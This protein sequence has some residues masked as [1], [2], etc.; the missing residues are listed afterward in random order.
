MS[1]TNGY[2]PFKTADE[3]ADKDYHIHSVTGDEYIFN[4]EKE[5]WRVMS[6]VKNRVFHS[7]TPPDRPTNAQGLDGYLPRQGDM[8]WDTNLMELRVWHEPVPEDPL[9][10]TPPGRWISSTNPHMSPLSPVKNRV[11]GKLALLDENDNTFRYTQ[12]Y[13]DTLYRIRCERTDST[14]EESLIGYSWTATPPSIDGVPVKFS[15]PSAAETSVEIPPLRRDSDGNVLQQQVSITC[16]VSAID[17]VETFIEPTK[18]INTGAMPIRDVPPGGQVQTGNVNVK[19][20]S[21]SDLGQPS[22]DSQPKYVVYTI[23]NDSFAFSGNYN[24]I[25]GWPPGRETYQI[26][27]ANISLTNETVLVDFVYETDS[28]MENYYLAFY[29]DPA[30][31]VP[32]GSTEVGADLGVIDPTLRNHRLIVDKEFFGNIYFTKFPAG[33]ENTMAGHIEWGQLPDP[34]GDIG[35]VTITGSGYPKKNVEETYSI[36]YAGSVPENRVTKTLTTDDPLAVVNGNK[37]TFGTTGYHQV[38]AVVKSIYASDSPQT[39]TIGVDV[40]PG[41]NKIGEFKISGDDRAVVG[42]PN[43]YT[44]SYDGDIV[45]HSVEFTTNDSGA[46]I[47]GGSIVFSQPGD[48]IVNGRITAT[49]S[50]EGYV[51]DFINVNVLT[52]IPSH[53]EMSKDEVHT[54]KP[55]TYLMVIDAVLNNKTHTWSTTRSSGGTGIRSYPEGVITHYTSGREFGEELVDGDVSGDSYVLLDRATAIDEGLF[56]TFPKIE[57]RTSVG[58]YLST[59]LDGQPDDSESISVTMTAIVEGGGFGPSLSINV[60]SLEPNLYTL[61]L[62]YTDEKI[63]GIKLISK[64]AGS[65]IAVHGYT[66]DNFLVESYLNDLIVDNGDGSAS[67]TMYKYDEDRTVQCI[68][69]GDQGRSVARLTVPVID[70]PEP[71]LGNTRFIQSTKLPISGETVY[72]YEF[73]TTKNTVPVSYSASFAVTDTNIPGGLGYEFDDSDVANGI[74][75]VKFPYFFADDNGWVS[76]INLKGQIAVIISD[77]REDDDLDES[78]RLPSSTATVSNINVGYPFK[79]APSTSVPSSEDFPANSNFSIGWI[80]AMSSD[81]DMTTFDLTSV[82]MMTATNENGDVFTADSVAT[83]HPDGRA[84]RTFTFDSLDAGTYVFASDVSYADNAGNSGDVVFR[85]TKSVS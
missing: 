72:T 81:V 13:E 33:S 38:F 16:T 84:N 32:W 77:A 34:E 39:S 80:G 83:V 6:A 67:I 54:G 48:F 15:H 7:P 24:N 42:I 61:P 5:S 69:D 68:A 78:G 26:Q 52:G 28:V 11:I 70:P 10:K 57:T 51:D 35:V 59:Y 71:S 21:D 47:T 2:E 19:V 65:R 20:L 17:K 41:L 8:W 50:V 29:E 46:T 27:T 56:I 44:Y 9:E 22:G 75:K 55:E 14:A 45:D 40:E 63:Q 66:V 36:T 85:M 74:L 3:V 23:D 60:K 64:T 1:T 31:T 49:D 76:F 30:R 25:E 82:T 62:P 12:V 18:K 58:L 37:I 53:I 4:A 43:A 73:E 79:M